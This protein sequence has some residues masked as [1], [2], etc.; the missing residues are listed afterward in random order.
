MSN[1][2][3]W[4]KWTVSLLLLLLLF[5]IIWLILHIRVLPK[6]A[7]VNKRDSAMIFDGEDETKATTFDAK[8]SKGQ[9]TVSGKY[10]GTKSGI[11]MGVKPGKESYLMKPKAKRSAEVNGASVRKMG[12]VT[13]NEAM[14]GSIKYVLNEE[15]GKLER[16]PKSDKPFLLKHGTPISYS[17]TMLNG[18]VPT[19]FTVN[20]KLNFKKK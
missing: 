16:I 1:I 5:I 12:N 19:P 18:G 8:M 17:G 13:I 11:I 2:P 6:N 14:I 3:L 15:N 10:A 9:M 7:H 4:I 20:T